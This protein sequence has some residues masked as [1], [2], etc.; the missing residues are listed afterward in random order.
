M[1]NRKEVYRISIPNFSKYN[2]RLKRGHKSTLISNR[3]CSD[4]KIQ[5]LPMHTRWLYLNLLLTCGD[6]CSNT[7]ETTEEQLRNMLE[8][9]QNIAKTLDQLQSFQLLTWQKSPLIEENRIEE[10]EE[11]DNALA[12]DENL[13]DDLDPKV[14]VQKVSSTKIFDERFNPENQLFV[15]KLEELGIT[16]PNII[17]KA[18]MVRER[19]KTIEALSEWVIGISQSKGFKE[20]ENKAGKVQYLAGALVGECKLSGVAS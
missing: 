1:K 3:F 6:H 13:K 18:F 17:G 5:A 4:A 16:S 12:K 20:K 15:K 8:T 19:F 9:R 7:V 10:R 14:Q 2:P 11:G